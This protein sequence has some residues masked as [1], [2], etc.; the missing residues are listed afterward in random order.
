MII[1][2]EQGVSKK[3]IINDPR[4]HTIILFIIYINGTFY[5][6]VHQWVVY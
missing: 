3:N 1:E 6:F 4:R 2:L 5:I